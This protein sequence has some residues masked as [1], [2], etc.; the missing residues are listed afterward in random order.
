[1][2]QSLKQ[3]LLEK[4]DLT[5]TRKHLL[6]FQKHVLEWELRPGHAEGLNS[7][8]LGIEK[9]YFFTKD[10]AALFDLFNIE[11]SVFEKLVHSAESVDPTRKVSSDPYNVLTMWLIYLINKSK[12][13]KAQ[14]EQFAFLLLKMVHYKYFTSFVN[15]SFP[16]GADLATMEY[17]IDHLSA[18]FDIKSA[19]TSTWRLVIEAR[20]KDVISRGGI[21]YRTLQTFAPDDKVLY[22]ITDTQTRLRSR[23][24]G[25]IQ[26]FYK[27]KELGNKV[28]SY[29][30]VDEFD[31]EKVINNV[32]ASFDQMIETI[33]N[34]VLNVNKFIN[35]EKMEIVLKLNSN[36]R[37]DMFR[38]LL[39]KFSDVAVQQYRKKEQSKTEGK[40]A[41]ELLIGYR[42]LIS[43]IIQKTYR[44]CILDGDTDMASRVAILEKTRNLYRSSRI[45][46][47]G[48][49]VIKNSVDHFVNLHSDS[50]R[51]STN[52][53]LKIAFIIYIIFMSFDSM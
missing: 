45:S 24:K 23:L 18:K 53:S 9:I 37:R 30:I 21:H 46:D 49:L 25:V 11:K 28:G 15:Y 43:N 17:T 39:L 13:P 20:S 14:K 41:H 31:G 48:I 44:A 19:E 27:N 33:S 35:R 26:S 10:I 34:D 32:V 2:S 1:M 6:Q 52:A 8:L 42:A 36:I 3:L 7:P 16:H 47:T 12:M 40:D 51:Q 5:L 4:Y 50:N 38:G 29:Q 22:I